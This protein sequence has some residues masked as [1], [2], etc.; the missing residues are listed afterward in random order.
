[1]QKKPF[2]ALLVW[3][4]LAVVPSAHVTSAIISSVSF[5]QTLLEA[6]GESVKVEKLIP[7]N[8]FALTVTLCVD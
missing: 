5:P 7:D 8:E 6:L 4:L 1:M 2:H 3:P